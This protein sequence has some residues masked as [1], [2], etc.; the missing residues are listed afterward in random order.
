MTTRQEVSGQVRIRKSVVRQEILEAARKWPGSVKIGARE[1]GSRG[2]WS[3]AL[4][5]RRKT[6]AT[7]RQ[8][9][10]KGRKPCRTREGIWVVAP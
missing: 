5:R 1:E 6:R 4:I 3:E 7:E 2:P 8:P 10:K 9:K